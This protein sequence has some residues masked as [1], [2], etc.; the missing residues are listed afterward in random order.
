MLQRSDS[1]APVRVA[2]RRGMNAQLKH[3]DMVH[4]MESPHRLL[5]RGAAAATI[6]EYSIASSDLPK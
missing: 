5:G 2:L 6:T 4:I 3:P 1:S